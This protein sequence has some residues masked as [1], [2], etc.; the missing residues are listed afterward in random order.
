MGQI[1]VTHCNHQ[2]LNACSISTQTVLIFFFYY[3]YW[4]T[5]WNSSHSKKIWTRYKNCINNM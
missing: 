4:Q 1:S 5:V 3:Y 2:L